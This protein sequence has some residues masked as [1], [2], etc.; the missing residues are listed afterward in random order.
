MSNDHIIIGTN[1]TLR[2]ALKQLNKAGCKCLIVVKNDKFVGT[3]SDGDIRKALLSSSN[4]KSSI[5]TIF[6]NFPLKG[7]N[8]KR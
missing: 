6:N 4:L 1:A 3:L 8:I 5:K 7:I 2:E